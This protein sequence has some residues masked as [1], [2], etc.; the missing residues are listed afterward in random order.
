LLQGFFIAGVPG[1]HGTSSP[2]IAL[3]FQIQL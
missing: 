1:N 3:H 2:L